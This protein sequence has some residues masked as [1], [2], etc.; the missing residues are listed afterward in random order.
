MSATRK[1]VVVTSEAMS[2]DALYRSMKN[3]S[4]DKVASMLTAIKSVASERETFEANVDR[5]LA[6]GSFVTGQSADIKH[7][8]ALCDNDSVARLFVALKIDPRAYIFPQSRDGGKSSTETS[9]LKAYKKAREVAECIWTG[10][11]TLENVARVFTTCA[12]R[13][14]QFGQEVLTR[15]FLEN[16]LSSREFRSINQGSVD[17][18]NAI[19]D[20]RAKHMSSGAQTQASQMVR[21]LVALKSAVDVRDGR[22]KHTRVDADGKVMQAL[23]RRFGQVTTDNSPEGDLTDVDAASSDVIDGD[24]GHTVALDY[25]SAYSDADNETTV[26]LLASE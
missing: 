16:F 18:W 15:D 20:V 3:V 11:S 8:Q 7:V 13:A 4:K 5:R 26:A 6:D 17:L 24:T 14:S 2:Q 9:N 12:Y 23:M 25:V 10:T 1:I 19:D 22:A 21:T